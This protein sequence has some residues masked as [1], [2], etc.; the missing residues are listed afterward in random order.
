MLTIFLCDRAGGKGTFVVV[1]IRMT[2]SNLANK[3]R[4]LVQTPVLN[5]YDLSRLKA[6]IYPL[7][8]AAPNR[9]AIVARPRGG[10]WLCEEVSA[11]F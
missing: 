9:I 7:T 4:K 8:A 5:S 10:D 2:D 6:T 11:L 1:L 3:R